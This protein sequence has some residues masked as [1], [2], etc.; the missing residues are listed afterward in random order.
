M[1]RGAPVKPGETHVTVDSVTP[2]VEGKSPAIAHGHDPQGNP[3]DVR[4]YGPVARQRRAG[5][6]GQLAQAAGDLGAMMTFDPGVSPA[7]REEVA[8]AL[9]RISPENQRKLIATGALR[10]IHIVDAPN[11]DGQLGG[12]RVGTHIPDFVTAGFYDPVS[13]EFYV[14]GKSIA[15]RKKIVTHEAMHALD[16]A[17][18]YPSRDA[19]W[20]RLVPRLAAG[21]G[22]Y[23]S[24]HFDPKVEGTQV[25]AQEMWA[26]LA[27]LTTQRRTLTLFN[28]GFGT[29]A[30]MNP[31]DTKLE[32]DVKAYFKR[33]GV[34]PAPVKRKKKT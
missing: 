29:L 24:D 25:A 6:A 11:V 20:R 10:K 14:A 30:A 34:V 15:A 9:S 22:K 19:E 12:S 27:A 33:L 13:R 31:G 5:D 4:L 28:T 17:L 26:E 2:R 3:V 18:G 7:V 1:A 21:G 32:A 16:K 8:T 23:L